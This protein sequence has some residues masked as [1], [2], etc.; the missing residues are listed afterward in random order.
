VE[1][2]EYLNVP[3]Q[4]SLRWV[5]VLLTAAAVLGLAPLT[6]IAAEAVWHLLGGLED[7]RK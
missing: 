3:L 6:L 1:S 7:P 5:R 4:R 2:Y